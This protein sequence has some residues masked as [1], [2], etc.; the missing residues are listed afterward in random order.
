L[1]NP[2]NSFKKKEWSMVH[3]FWPRDSAMILGRPTL[4][5]RAQ[6]RPSSGAKSG[7]EMINPKCWLIAATYGSQIGLII[8]YLIP[9]FDPQYPQ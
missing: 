2:V 6:S 8:S 7:D 4:R 3:D 1:E 5:K 9:N